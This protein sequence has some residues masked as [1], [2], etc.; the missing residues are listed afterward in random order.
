MHAV[1]PFKSSARRSQCCGNAIGTSAQA[2]PIPSRA[3]WTTA[4]SHGPSSRGCPAELGGQPLVLG[5]RVASSARRPGL[6]RLHGGREGALASDGGQLGGGGGGGG[7]G[8]GRLV[9]PDGRRRRRPD[10]FAFADSFAFEVVFE[11]DCWIAFS[12]EGSFEHDCW[13]AFSF[14]GSFE[15]SLPCKLVFP[16]PPSG[17]FRYGS[18]YLYLATSVL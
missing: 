18:C 11:H 14:E 16:G 2:Q 6:R 3:G 17:M 5:A 15:H 8:R 9:R 12:F 10:A 13:I 4:R 7:D 1:E